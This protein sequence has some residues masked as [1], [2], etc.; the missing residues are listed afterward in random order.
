MSLTAG[1]TE[2]EIELLCALAR[3]PLPRDR[4]GSC[5]DGTGRRFHS[6]TL[7]AAEHY[8]LIRLNPDV[9]P[10][11]AVEITAAGRRCLLSVGYLPTPESVS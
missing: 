6:N 10:W 1:L 9:V 8:G 11:G 5:G 3:A 2:T 4:S 7:N